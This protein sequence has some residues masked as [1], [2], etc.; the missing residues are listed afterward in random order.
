M[1]TGELD[2]SAMED[3]VSDTVALSETTPKE[4]VTTFPQ[5]AAESGALKLKTDLVETKP[6]NSLTNKRVKDSRSMEEHLD[7][8]VS[9][10]SI[11][12]NIKRES[13]RYER[14][15]QL[16]LK[17]HSKQKNKPKKEFKMKRK[18]V[19]TTFDTKAL[20]GSSI[21]P[22]KS[23]LEEEDAVQKLLSHMGREAD[24]VSGR[25]QGRGVTLQNSLKAGLIT[26]SLNKEGETT[27]DDEKYFETHCAVTKKIINC[28]RY[29]GHCS[30]GTCKLASNKS[31]STRLENEKHR[32]LSVWPNRVKSSLGARNS[33]I[34]VVKDPFNSRRSLAVQNL[35]KNMNP[36]NHNG[37]VLNRR[38]I[39][40]RKCPEVFNDHFARKQH[41][42]IHYKLACTVCGKPFKE[43]NSLNM[44]MRIHAPER[45]FSCDICGKGFNQKG[46][47][48]THKE[49]NHNKIST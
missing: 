16:K 2:G 44:H 36:K 31:I 13:L 5:L 27:R 8:T 21:I 38:K 12:Y 29:K 43:V 1:Y 15:K 22:V 14:Y 41:M 23:S 3:I 34:T 9:N 24:R 19:P 33:T 35:T 25:L 30:C 26:I 6:D 10:V 28:T 11:N 17:P 49:K 39:N 47:L 4:E 18:E 48:Y 37:K 40:C 45:P 32:N 20:K 42:A 7:Y 46:N